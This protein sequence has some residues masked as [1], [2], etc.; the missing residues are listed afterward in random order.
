MDSGYFH[1][2]AEGFL[3]PATVTKKSEVLGS[4]V[5]SFVSDC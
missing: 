1:N 5:G 3:L 2:E 4:L